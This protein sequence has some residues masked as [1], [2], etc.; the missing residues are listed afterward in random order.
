M[1]YFFSFW[2][3]VAGLWAAEQA[4]ADMLR[5]C[6]FLEDLAGLPGEL[7]MVREGR[8]DVAEFRKNLSDSARKIG[9]RRRS[10]VLTNAERRVL[11]RFLRAIRDDWHRNG[12]NRLDGQS[13]L[14][15]PHRGA[16]IT[17]AGRFGCNLP[18]YEEDGGL[19]GVE[20]APIN[21]LTVL[22]ATVALIAAVVSLLRIMRFGRRERRM[23]CRVPAWLRLGDNTYS[24]QIMNISRGGVMVEA[25]EPDIADAEVTLGLPS[26]KI[27]S[28]VVWTNSNF[29]G[30][31]FEKR[32]SRKMVKKIA[33]QRQTDTPETDAEEPA[34]PPQVAS[35]PPRSVVD[36]ASG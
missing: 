19:S 13:S 27:N 8:G 9:D 33:R 18:V 34:M 36:A 26:M 23:I 2:V 29:A 21:L 25:P 15:V 14:S 1:Q 32:I 17:I 7:H 5:T 24:T 20:T 16:V 3:F 30:L 28:R 12:L 4:R 35:P 22:V 6:V 11:E 31:V 10:A